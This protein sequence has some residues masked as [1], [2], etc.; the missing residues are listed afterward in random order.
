MLKKNLKKLFALGL[1]ATLGIGSLTACGGSDVALEKSSNVS[2]VESAETDKDTDNETAQAPTEEAAE[3]ETGGEDSFGKYEETIVL[4][5]GR[6]TQ[7]D[8]KL[9]EGDSYEDNAYTRYLKERL[10]VQIEDEFEAS[11]DEYDRQT[12]LAIAAGEIPDILTVRTEDVLQELVDAGLVAD[13]TEVYDQY[14]S[15][16]LKNI[17]SSYGEGAF[18]SVTFDGKL[19][20][21][22]G[23][24][25]DIAPQVI[26]VRQ[27]WLDKLNMTV[28][29]DGDGCLTLSELEEIAAAFVENDPGESG[30]PVGFAMDANALN[31]TEYGASCHT[32][33][34]IAGVFDC[35]PEIWYR[36]AE[37]NLTYGSTTEGMKETLAFL[38]GWFEKGLLDPQVAT[39]TYDDIAALLANN[40]LGIT[41]GPY[42]FPGWGLANVKTM[43]PEADFAC[44]TLCDDEGNVNV[45]R[46]NFIQRYVVVSS[47]CENPEA[48]VKIMNVLYDELAFGDLETIAPEVFEYV[49]LG[50]DN[51]VKPTWIECMDAS[52]L[53]T[54][55]AMNM[56]ALNGET[57]I[58]SLPTPSQQNTVTNAK[59]YMEN[60]EEA[61]V[62]E[63][64]SYTGSI[65]GVSLL[66][67]LTEEN[68]MKKTE[69]VFWGTTD[70]MKKKWANLE[71]LEAESF[72]KIITGAEPIDYFDTFVE[73][74]LSQ[75]GQEIIDE[76][77]A[78]TK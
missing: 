30:S 48:V 51:S 17:Y 28:D 60:P 76:I 2:E 47:E 18:D 23:T 62:A 32:M 46:M 21:L 27:D 41:T 54:D 12:S 57:E 78:L 19:M 16:G 9:P 63:W 15:D 31:C 50:V 1:I 7:A 36:D 43:N 39:R 4:S 52:K 5:A 37:G 59:N 24:F 65:K 20:A 66:N 69:P 10:N 8:P 55:Y 42:H 35:Y 6:Y 44:Y 70:T 40:Q 38:N 11:Q 72:I 22:P 29:E 68:K 25:Y 58:E 13:L 14:A 56:A 33:T 45:F 53:L 49:K 3:Q 75:G 77:D 71:A 26:F 67:Q 74:W 34:G 61:T 64:I 73:N